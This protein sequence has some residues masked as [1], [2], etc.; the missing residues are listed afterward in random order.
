MLAS[1]R[2][3]AWRR[4]AA[5]VSPPVPARN[6]GRTIS[7]AAWGLR[8]RKVSGTMQAS[9]PTKHRARPC[10]ALQDISAAKRQ[11][12]PPSVPYGA[13]TSPYRGGFANG[14]RPKGSPARGAVGV[15]RL[16]GAAPCP[17]NILPGRRRL[18]RS[19]GITDLCGAALAQNRSITLP[20]ASPA[21]EIARPTMQGK[22]AAEAAGMAGG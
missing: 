21:G 22:R 20:Q 16:R 13:S 10:Q 2:G 6:V 8:H 19:C 5:S 12:T 1:A 7:P 11:C 17:A 15:S 9:S 3:R 18:P 14:F 4:T